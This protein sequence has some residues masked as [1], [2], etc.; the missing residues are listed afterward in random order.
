MKKAHKVLLERGEGPTNTGDHFKDSLSL[1][2]YSN[3]ILTMA[4]VLQTEDFQ[5]NDEVK[6]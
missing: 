2:E 3:K 6:L 5:N 4:G 1:A